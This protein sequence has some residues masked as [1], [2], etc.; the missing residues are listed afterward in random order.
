MVDHLNSDQGKIYVRMELSRVDVEVQVLHKEMDGR[1][2][3]VHYGNNHGIRSCCLL[4][5]SP[6][7]GT[8]M[9]TLLG[10]LNSQ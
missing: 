7:S 4:K 10:M 5:T 8:R 9:V 6:S 3:E 1:G 2:A